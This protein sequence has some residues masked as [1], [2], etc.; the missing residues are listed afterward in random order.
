MNHRSSNSQ[1]RG[2]SQGSRLTVANRQAAAK[3]RSLHLNSAPH[4]YAVRTSVVDI[5]PY[6]ADTIYSRRVRLVGSVSASAPFVVL[7]SS[8]RAAIG[9]SQ[10]TFF[11]AMFVRRMSIWGDDTNTL[12][13]IPSLCATTALSTPDRDFSDVGII[14][15]RRAHVVIEVSPKDSNA[16]SVFTQNVCTVNTSSTEAHNVIADFLVEFSGTGT[17]T[18]GFDLSEIS[19][20]LSGVG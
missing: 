15:S 3:I 18:F 5:P 20:S 12:R 11:T 4:W 2:R 17:S 9:L 13:V 10:A 14:G 16:C 7:Y 8:L 1:G 19:S 6:V